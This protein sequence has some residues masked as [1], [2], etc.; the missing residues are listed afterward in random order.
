MPQRFSGALLTRC[1]G[2]ALNPA[3][4]QQFVGGDP[5]GNA[6]LEGYFPV[7]DGPNEGKRNC[8]AGGGNLGAK[9]LDDL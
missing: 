2:C 3:V 1:V 6:V 4:A 7:D 9:A 5:G 8:H